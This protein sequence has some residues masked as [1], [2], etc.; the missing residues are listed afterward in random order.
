MDTW[1]IWLGSWEIWWNLIE[2]HVNQTHVSDHQPHPVYPC[3][4]LLMLIFVYAMVV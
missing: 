3:L 1:Q 2:T 4:L